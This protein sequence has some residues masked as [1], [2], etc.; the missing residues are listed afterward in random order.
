[1]TP[2]FGSI[3]RL[4][5]PSTPKP[6]GCSSRITVCVTPRGEPFHVPVK[7][8]CPSAR[9]G[10]GPALVAAAP[11][12]LSTPASPP[13]RPSCPA[14]GADA[15]ANIASVAMD[16]TKRVR[17][18]FLLVEVS[19]PRVVDAQ[20]IE[21]RRAFVVKQA[22]VFLALERHANRPRPRKHFRIGHRGFVLQRVRVDRRVALDHL[23]RVAVV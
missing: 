13:G 1:M 4:L 23:Q 20:V 12:V 22:D 7:S 14:T 15:A 2:S 5:P 3:M 9:R 10:I 11:S 21:H 16:N 6:G 17:I 18:L 19:G 8:G